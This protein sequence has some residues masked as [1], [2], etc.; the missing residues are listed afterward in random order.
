MNPAVGQTPPLVCMRATN[1]LG[2]RA[3]LS[4]NW[5][6]P[7]ATMPEM[8]RIALAYSTLHAREQRVEQ[9]AQ[10]EKAKRGETLPLKARRARLPGTWANSQR[11]HLKCILRNERDPLPKVTQHLAWHKRRGLLGGGD[12]RAHSSNLRYVF[13]LQSGASCAQGCPRDSP[14]SN[15]SSDGVV[16]QPHRVCPRKPRGLTLAIYS[17]YSSN[18]I[19]TPRLTAS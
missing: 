11:K 7:P 6:S 13:E 4:A 10:C 18:G 5:K 15:V 19:C 14:G 12:G 3:A 17:I 16:E 1:A 9:G 8:A 2:T